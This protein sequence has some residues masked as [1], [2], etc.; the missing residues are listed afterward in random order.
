MLLMRRASVRASGTGSPL[1]DTITSPDLM[2]ALAAGLPSCGSATSAPLACFMPRLSAMSA[3]TGWICTP[4]HPRVTLPPSLSWLTTDFT[5]SAGIANAMPT[6]PPDGEKIAVLTPITLPSTARVGADRLGGVG[7]AVIGRDLDALGL[8]DHVVVGHRV[9]V[10]RDEE[11]R[12]LPGGEL[13]PRRAAQARTLARRFLAEA[14][15]E[16]LERRVLAE[17]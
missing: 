8:V 12:A 3:V 1:S 15:K 13:A 7:L 14:A 2:P 10:G 5:V 9:A 4:I 11:A 16:E 17:R 6:E